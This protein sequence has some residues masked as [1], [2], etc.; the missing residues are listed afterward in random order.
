MD[1]RRFLAASG[2]A[3]LATGRAGAAGAAAGRFADAEAARYRVTYGF[4]GQVGEIVTTLRPRA[5]S[6]R[7]FGR[8][9][10]SLL[11]L[12]DSYK[13]IESELEPTD[14][15][16][17]RWSS[18]RVTGDDTI[19]DD[20]AQPR[21]GA[22]ELVRRRAGRPDDRLQVNVP[23]PVSDP[24]GFLLRLRAA[25]PA[26]GATFHV[27]DGRGLWLVAIQ[28]RAAVRGE[29]PALRLDARADLLLWSGA[30]HPE[31]RNREFSLWLAEDAYR[32]P[33][34]VETRLGPGRVAVEL[35]EV[36]RPRARVAAAGPTVWERAQHG[37]G[38]L[39]R[40]LARLAARAPGAR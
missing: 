35:V 13:R 3:A 33:L 40:R 34:R 22:L 21:P 32:T 23:G 16:T 6:L 12:G 1:R 17:R 10:G 29:A 28:D 15:S 7:A 25:P 37:A 19:V 31:K 38:A 26:P 2:A 11:G 18:V 20:G 14:L 27:L 4:L 9:Q 39:L 36:N 5:S 8:G 24:L 30:L